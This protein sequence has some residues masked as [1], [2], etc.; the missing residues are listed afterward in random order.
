MAHKAWQ[1]ANVVKER[2]GF[3]RPY[4][5]DLRAHKAAQALQAA[6]RG[7][8]ERRRLNRLIDELTDPRSSQEKCERHPA[9]Y[10]AR[11]VAHLRSV[12]LS[13]H[14]SHGTAR[15]THACDLADRA[16]PTALL[17]HHDP[18]VYDALKDS[19][20]FFK[21]SSF[22]YVRGGSTRVSAEGVAGESKRDASTRDT[23]RKSRR[24]RLSQGVQLSPQHIQQFRGFVHKL[25][26]LDRRR[27]KLAR[28]RYFMEVRSVARL[29]LPAPPAAMYSRARR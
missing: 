28:A 27:R 15:L 1:R 16:A 11:P 29:S 21:T 20:A 25:D 12:P 8:D 9:P 24:I 19:S 7:R 2:R 10:H 13:Q 22:K 6:W 5:T 26:R 14:P 4:L 3:L 18:R 23:T 17:A